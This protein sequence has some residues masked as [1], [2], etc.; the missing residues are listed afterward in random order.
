MK[1]QFINIIPLIFILIMVQ[2]YDL[3][4]QKAFPDWHS[5]NVNWATAGYDS[6][7]YKAYDSSTL[8]WGETYILQTFNL[9]YQTDR[10]TLWLH[11]LAKHGYGIMHSAKDTPP[12]T[13]AFN[14]QYGRWISWLGDLALFR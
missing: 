4:S 6:A 13:I 9:M 10:D 14:G 5:S 7:Y 1:K 11:K 3:F 8:A 12:D 2:S